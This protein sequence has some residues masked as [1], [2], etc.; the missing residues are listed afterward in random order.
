MESP[1]GLVITFDDDKT[2][3]DIIIQKLRQGG[4][5]VEGKPVFLK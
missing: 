3:V 5:R 1:D 4:H 2:S